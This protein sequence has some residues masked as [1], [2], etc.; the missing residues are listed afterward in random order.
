MTTCCVETGN[1]CKDG[2]TETDR[3]EVWA[4]YRP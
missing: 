1:A 4:D 3:Q 2:W